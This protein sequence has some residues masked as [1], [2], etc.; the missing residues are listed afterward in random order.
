LIAGGRFVG[1]RQ[2]H[3]FV[4]FD[5]NRNPGYQYVFVNGSW[6][7]MRHVAPFLRIENVLD[8]EYQEVLGYSALSRNVIGGVRIKW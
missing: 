4:F 7:A 2:E 3:D 8:A 5:V 1:E 6:Q